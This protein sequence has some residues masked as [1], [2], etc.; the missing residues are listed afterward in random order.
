MSVN[1]KKAERVVLAAYEHVPYYN[2]LFL[3]N[4][5]D[6]ES[7]ALSL[8]DIPVTTK[9]NIR[10]LGIVNF[11]NN[12]SLRRGRLIDRDDVQVQQT[13][14]TTGVPM[15]IPW[16]KTDYYA[17]TY[18]HWKLRSRYGNVTAVSRQCSL[19]F[20]NKKEDVF[21]VTENR[22]Q[23][24][25]AHICPETVREYLHKMVD[26]RPEWIYMQPSILIYLI[27]IAQK[28]NIDIRGEIRYIES[29]SEPLIPAYRKI[30][31]SYFGFPIHNMYGCEETNGI[32]FE[33]DHGR[34]HVMSGNVIVQIVDENGRSTTNGAKGNVCVTGL[35]NTLMPIIRYGLND[36]A[37]LDSTPCPCGNKNPSLQLF[38]ARITDI[39]LLNDPNLTGGAELYY[40]HSAFSDLDLSDFIPF[41]LGM[42]EVG[43]TIYFPDNENDAE[44]LFHEFLRI[45]AAYGMENAIFHLISKD[46]AK[47]AGKLGYLKPTSK[48][49]E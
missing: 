4:G 18:H 26:F 45:M 24:N 22:L 6:P 28:E 47:S 12:S 20:S 49:A 39:L 32:A 46:E 43:R 7:D 38:S 37:Q 21:I 14:G 9:E 15:S 13:T 2:Q 34:M 27:C 3:N 10:E 11:L 29:V 41:R 25:R 33:C 44:T 5:L 23:I 16:Y 1:E 42:S 31:E 30:I 36:I 8:S 19:F 48:G 40:P 17:S 35:H